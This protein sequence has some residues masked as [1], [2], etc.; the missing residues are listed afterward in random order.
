MLRIGIMRSGV[1]EVLYG[2][3]LKERKIQEVGFG[4]GLS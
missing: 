3:Q 1:P 2:F 4:A